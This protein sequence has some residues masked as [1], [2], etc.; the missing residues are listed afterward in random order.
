MEWMLLKYCLTIQIMPQRL[1][2]L[3][4]LSRAPQL[5]INAL[6]ISVI[7]YSLS[8]KVVGIQHHLNNTTYRTSRPSWSRYSNNQPLGEV[9]VFKSGRYSS[10]PKWIVAAAII[11]S[12]TN[13]WTTLKSLMLSGLMPLLHK[14]LIQLAFQAMDKAKWVRIAMNETVALRVQVRSHLLSRPVIWSKVSIFKNV[15]H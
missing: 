15:K 14:E 13:F 4:R 6:T 1:P 11:R 2:Q 8:L 9:L 5:V 7:S 3:Q 12:K 10:T